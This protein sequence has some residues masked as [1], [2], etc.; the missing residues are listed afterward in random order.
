M[1]S[2]IYKKVLGLVVRLEVF[3]NEGT[4][5]GILKGKSIYVQ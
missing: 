4:C 3:C 2:S 1:C 5:S